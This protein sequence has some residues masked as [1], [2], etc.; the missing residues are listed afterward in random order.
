MRVYLDCEFLEDGSTIDLISLAMVTDDGDEFYMINAD[1]PWR[2][3]LAH[4][5]LR[6]NVVSYLP[7]TREGMI[8]VHHADVFTRRQ[9]AVRA[10]RFIQD[11][12]RPE[13]WALYGAYDFVALCQLWGPLVN[14]PPGIPDRINDVVQEYRRYGYTLP[15]RQDDGGEHHPLFDAHYAR[16]SHHHILTEREQRHA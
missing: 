2:R 13:L 11:V 3:I 9:I 15:A 5:W 6:E 8:D 16:D 14:R 12:D 7:R 4:D 1:A 10:A